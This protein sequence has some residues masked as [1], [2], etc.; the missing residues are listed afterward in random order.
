MYYT[1]RGVCRQGQIIPS[2]PVKYESSEE[3]DVII[4]FL[5][6]EKDP[7]KS[8][9]LTSEDEV[10][11]TMGERAANGRFADASEC[12]DRYLYGGSPLK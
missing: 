4:T 3:L 10:L 1:I 7:G 11:Y 5:L 8:E 6:P 2:E 12:H 9:F